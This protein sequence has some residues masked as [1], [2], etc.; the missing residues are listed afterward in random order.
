MIKYNKFY[1]QL[2]PVRGRYIFQQP[3][4]TE[5]HEA[6][7]DGTDSLWSTFQS[8]NLTHNHRQG[9]DHVFADL[10]NRIREGK[11]THDDLEVLKERVCYQADAN[12]LNCV[13]ICATVSEACEYNENQTSKLEGKLYELK[14]NNFCQNRKN[15]S[16]PVDKAGRIASTQFMDVLRLKVGSRVMLIFNLGICSLTFISIYILLYF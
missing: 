13:R 7:G 6:Y 16:P 4:A 3:S 12:L 8:V 11:Q 1:F 10:L 2:K 5:Y 15:F 14:A 9:E